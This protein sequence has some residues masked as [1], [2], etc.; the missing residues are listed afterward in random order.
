MLLLVPFVVDVTL[1][2]RS[3][4]LERDCATTT[5]AYDVLFPH[6]LDPSAPKNVESMSATDTTAIAAMATTTTPTLSTSGA[7]TICFL[8]RFHH[9]SG[10]IQAPRTKSERRTTTTT[11]GR[12]GTTFQSSVTSRIRHN[13]QPISES[14]DVDDSQP[15]GLERNSRR[16]LK[17]AVPVLIMTTI[18]QP[19]TLRGMHI[20]L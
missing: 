7:G 15:C 20:S 13:K 14:Y 18:I 3:P 17:K 2:R 10:T 1:M 5:C 11:T 9:P 12:C 19:T 4:C 6:V 8:E 16:H